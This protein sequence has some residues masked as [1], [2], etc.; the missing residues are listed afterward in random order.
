ME[1]YDSQM[2]KRV[3]D[4]VYKEP[5]QPREA[6]GHLM[7]CEAQILADYT[8]LQRRFP[9]MKTLAED[10]RKSIACLRGIRYLQ[11]GR[12]PETLPLKQKEDPADIVLRRCYML[13]AKTAAE[14]SSR[15]EDPEYGCIYTQ[16][17]DIKRRHCRILLE[18]LG[19]PERTA[20]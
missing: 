7:M 18:L 4:R 12:L 3:W 5:E 10:T 2:A 16:M 19:T 11:E 6:P 13:S 8:R 9:E 14:L 17:A 20:K 1:K 15:A